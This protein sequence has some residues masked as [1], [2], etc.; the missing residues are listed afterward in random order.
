M[1]NGYPIS[2]VSYAL[3]CTQYKD[4][5]KGTLVKAYFDYALGTGQDS[6]DSLG[7][8]PLPSELDTK[9]TQSIDSVS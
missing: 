1:T 5:T 2:T 6:A 7:F 9:S 4:A 8:A 3:V